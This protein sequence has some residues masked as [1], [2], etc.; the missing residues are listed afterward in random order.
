MRL[1]ERMTAEPVVISQPMHWLGMDQSNRRN[2]AEPLTVY[3][4]SLTLVAAPD[5]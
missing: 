5:A 2:D 3:P 4:D 1:G